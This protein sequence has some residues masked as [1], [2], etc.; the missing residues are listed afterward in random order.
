MNKRILRRSLRTVLPKAP[1]IAEVGQQLVLE[2][3]DFTPQTVIKGYM[4]GHFPTPVGNAIRWEAP[5]QR[6]QIPIQNFHIPKNIKRLVRQQKFEIRFDTSFEEVINACADRK[7]SWISN[8]IIDV[9][10]QL[11][12]MRVASSVEAW[13]DGELVGGLYGIRIGGYFATESQFHRVRDAG[14]VAFVTLFETL[15]SN[16][17]LLHDVQ[18]ITPYLK[19]FGAIE[20]TN[21]AFRETVANAMV[22]Q[23]TWPMAEAQVEV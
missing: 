12:E 20:M 21:S 16:G 4:N 7:D 15:K 19:Q 17:F 5:A 22:R 18:N 14:K 1:I 11:N 2:S 9:Y 10:I 13:L 23:T 6:A 3:M 8:Q